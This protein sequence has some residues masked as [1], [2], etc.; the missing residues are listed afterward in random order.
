MFWTW[1]DLYKKNGV[2]YLRQLEAIKIQVRRRS[3]AQGINL[4]EPMVLIRAKKVLLNMMADLYS[5]HT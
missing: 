4:D 2:K 3:R 1:V 5:K